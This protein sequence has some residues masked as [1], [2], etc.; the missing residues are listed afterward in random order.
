MKKVYLVA[1]VLALIFGFSYCYKKDKTEKTETATEKEAVVNEVKNEDM[2]IPGYALGEIPSIT[3]PEI[4]NLSVSENPDAK[5]TLDMTKKISSV[6]GITISPVKVENGNIVDGSYSMQIGKNGDGQ[7]INKVTGVILQVDKDGT[8]LYT[9]NKNNIKIYVGEIN[10]RYESPNV[11]IINNGDGSGTYTDKSKNLVIENDGK[12]K[13]KITFNGQTTEVDAKPLEKPGKLEMVP[14]V[15]SIEANSLLITSDSGILFD[16]DK[17]DVRP[18]DKEVLKNLATVLKEMNVKNFEID[19]YTDSDG[20]DEHNQVL[21]EKRA[22]SVKNFLV[23]QGVTAEITTKG[24]GESKPVA[25]N[26]TAEGRQ[27]NRRVEII[28][29]TI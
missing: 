14:P 2:V 29:P 21:S 24:Y 4:Q 16:V 11:E 27:K 6:P 13:A 18:E 10:A 9:D 23:S 20:S 25:S 8:G 22:N 15:P 26:D 5:I 17:Y 28:I 3:I 1:A 19:G 12:G 7:Y